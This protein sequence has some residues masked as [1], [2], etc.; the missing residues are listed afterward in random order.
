MADPTVTDPKLPAVVDA[1]AVVEAAAV[2]E[3]FAVNADE[4]AAFQAWLV[5]Q[6]PPPEVNDA[7]MVWQAVRNHYPSGVPISAVFTPGTIDAATLQLQYKDG[8]LW[9]LVTGGVVC[10]Q[11]EAL[12][13]SQDKLYAKVTA[14]GVV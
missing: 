4:Y 13:L 7:F 10:S 11:D 14:T 12:E 5:T 9:N 1:P 3:T 8:S 2:Q 6:E